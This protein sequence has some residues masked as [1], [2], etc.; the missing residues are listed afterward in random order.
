M[1]SSAYFSFC[2]IALLASC[3]EPE[4]GSVTVNLKDGPASAQEVNIEVEQVDIYIDGVRDRGWY[5]LKTN[6]GIYDLLQFQDISLLLASRQGL[7]AG[8]VTQVRLTLG[9]H[10][11]IKD[12][13]YHALETRG[14][15]GEK[16]TVTLPAGFAIRNNDMLN[17]L[18]HIDAERSIIKKE[19]NRYIL[20]PLATCA[21]ISAPMEPF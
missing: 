18:V 13:I 7:P 17:I 10:N 5:T 14:P 9:E 12:E 1:R 2:L 21:T 16:Y 15:P 20:E 8:K 11:S 4:F 3:K 6:R 19:S